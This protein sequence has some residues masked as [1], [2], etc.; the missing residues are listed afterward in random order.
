MYIYHNNFIEIFNI[1]YYT[2]FAFRQFIEI[3]NNTLNNENKSFE[4]RKLK[5]TLH[6]SLN[7]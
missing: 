5:Y 7:M 2:I 4:K 3:C 6:F 1:Y